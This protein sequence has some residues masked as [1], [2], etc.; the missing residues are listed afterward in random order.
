VAQYIAYRGLSAMEDKDAD[1]F[2]G[3]ARETLEVINALAG[4]P[5]I[6]T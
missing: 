6:R 3:R 2:F 4:T 1:Y 5:G